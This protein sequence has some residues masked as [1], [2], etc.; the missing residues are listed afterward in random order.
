[1]GGGIGTDKAG[2]KDEEGEWGGLLRIRTGMLF[3]GIG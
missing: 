3:S 1:M 2:G